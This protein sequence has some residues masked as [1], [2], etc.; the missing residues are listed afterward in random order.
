M[1]IFRKREPQFQVI[2]QI[3]T[4]HCVFRTAESQAD[5]DE[6]VKA[7][8]ESPAAVNIKVYKLDP[9]GA[10]ELQLERGEAISSTIKKPIGFCR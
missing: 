4:G 1:R 10:Y 5:V 2:V 8:E 6:W 7:F 3:P 9:R